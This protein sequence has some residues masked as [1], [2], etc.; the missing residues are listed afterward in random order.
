MT[1][2][3]AITFS[4]DDGVTQ[5]IRLI[6]IL[7]KYGLKA[8][9]NLNSSYLGCPGSLVRENS[10]VSHYKVKA[11]EVKDL[12]AGHEVASHTLTHPA[13]LCLPD[14]EVVRQVE[15]DRQCLSSLV[16]Y[17]VVGLAYPCGSHTVDERVMNLVRTKTGIRYAR[18]TVSSF[19]C[20]PPSDLI[21]FQ[22]SVYIPYEW[23]KAQSMAEEFLAA[24][25]NTPQ[26]FYL[27]A[28]AYE[29]DVFHLWNRFEEF[30]KKIARQGDIFYGTNSEVLLSSDWS[31]P[32]NRR[33]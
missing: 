23:E 10:V 27:W 28:H 20:D 30:C 8:T 21:H 6:Q 32:S 33:E 16:G 29:F 18:G 2:K 4:F 14:D 13:L 15:E 24:S 11:E 1:V 12:Y 3:K 25:P 31:I 22:P 5:D 7:N 17:E 19:S 26:I 9:F